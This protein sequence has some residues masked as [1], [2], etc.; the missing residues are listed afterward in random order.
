MGAG[1]GA[2]S[3]GFNGVVTRAGKTCVKVAKIHIGARR[4]GR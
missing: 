3:E 4:G 2:A 1:C